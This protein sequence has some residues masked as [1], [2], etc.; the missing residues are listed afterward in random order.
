LVPTYDKDGDI[1]KAKHPLEDF[2]F[3]EVVSQNY[4]KGKKYDYK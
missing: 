3:I 4:L 1:N 2:I